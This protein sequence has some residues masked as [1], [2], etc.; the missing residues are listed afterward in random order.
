MRQGLAK[1]LRLGSQAVDNAVSELERQEEI[2]ELLA[3]VPRSWPCSPALLRFLHLAEKTT[4]E[5]KLI[6]TTSCHRQNFE[7][8]E[9]AF[10]F[11]LCQ[12]MCA[13]RVTQCCE[14]SNRLLLVF[15]L[16]FLHLCSHNRRQHTYT[17]HLSQQK[18]R[19][20]C[21]AQRAVIIQ[22]MH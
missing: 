15:P 16:R 19:Q 20:P 14:E 5:A 11:S 10:E 7:V 8:E 22:G 13:K 2:F 1:Q 9:D 18:Q 21:C 17:T 12:P 6:F 3:L 4:Q